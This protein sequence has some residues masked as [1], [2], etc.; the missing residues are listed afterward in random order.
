MIFNKYDNERVTCTKF[1]SRQ[2]KQRRF[3]R[4][5]Y[6]GKIRDVA[7]SFDCFLIVSK[8]QLHFLSSSLQTAFYSSS[9]Y[10]SLNLSGA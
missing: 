5:T 10:V 2:E 3:K 6:Q 8:L 7:V 1:Q 4:R 9:V